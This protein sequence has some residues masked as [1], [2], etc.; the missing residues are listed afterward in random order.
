L[1]A[2]YGAFSTSVYAA[3]LIVGAQPVT[4]FGSFQIS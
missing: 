1:V 2:V 4:V 3:A